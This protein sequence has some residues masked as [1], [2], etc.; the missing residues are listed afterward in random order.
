MKY[1]WMINMKTITQNQNSVLTSQAD[2][3]FIFIFVIEI[4]RSPR[5]LTLRKIKALLQPLLK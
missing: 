4:C 1:F 2:E 5:E 3:N